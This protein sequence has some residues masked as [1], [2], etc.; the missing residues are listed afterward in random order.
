MDGPNENGE[1]FRFEQ[2]F[3]EN[4]TYVMVGKTK[5]EFGQ[6]EAFLIL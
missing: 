1:L 6:N 3:G 5:I 2:R 4:Q